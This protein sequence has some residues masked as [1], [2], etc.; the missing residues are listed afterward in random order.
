MA[1]TVSPRPRARGL[2]EELDTSDEQAWWLDDF[3][4]FSALKGGT[5][6]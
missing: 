6:T 2:R 1:S 5:A 4:L 3:V